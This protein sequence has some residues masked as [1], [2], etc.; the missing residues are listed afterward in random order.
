MKSLGVIF[1]RFNASTHIESI[2]EGERERLMEK[3][4]KMM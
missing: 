4:E 1:H 2:L 3:V